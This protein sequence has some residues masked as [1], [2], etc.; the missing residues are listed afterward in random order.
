MPFPSG[1]KIGSKQTL[2]YYIKNIYKDFIMI[3]FLFFF[4]FTVDSDTIDEVVLVKKI[5]IYCSRLHHE[6]VGVFQLFN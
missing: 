2:K 4:F 3:F 5:K 1:F 6:L